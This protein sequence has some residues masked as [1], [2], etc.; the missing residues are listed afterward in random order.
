MIRN[1]LLGWLPRDLEPGF[2]NFKGTQETIPRNQFR[3][4]TYEACTTPY[5]YSVPSPQ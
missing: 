1:R 2:L 3:Q 5:S 4:P